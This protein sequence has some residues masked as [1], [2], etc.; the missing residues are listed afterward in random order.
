MGAPQWQRV[1]LRL[2]GGERSYK[3]RVR[4]LIVVGGQF[5]RVASGVSAPW[6]GVDTPVS[7][8][9]SGAARSALL[10]AQR[11]KNGDF[12]G[13]LTQKKVQTWRCKFSTV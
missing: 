10:P 8:P 7:P 5:F 4:A 2:C 3:V 13:G 1:A 9:R 11:E 6:A 12:G